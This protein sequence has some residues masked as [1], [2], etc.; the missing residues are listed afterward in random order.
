MEEVLT[1]HYNP[2]FLKNFLITSAGKNESL[3]DIFQRSAKE[4][5]VDAKVYTSD[6]EP[7]TAPACR[8]SDGSF[9]VPQIT[10]EDYM[11]VLQSICLGN[12]VKVVI[13]TTERELPILSANKDI[14][15]KLGIHILTPDYEFIMRCMDNHQYN[16]YLENL[17]IDI[18]TSGDINNYETLVEKYFTKAS[19]A[20]YVVRK[21][22]LGEMA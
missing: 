20:D 18:S 1:L 17:G 12:H 13:P 5:G 22:L 8:A 21:Y 4:L 11:K 3:V 15:A 16:G 10:S 7:G 19:F 9:A 14:F 2:V 6:M